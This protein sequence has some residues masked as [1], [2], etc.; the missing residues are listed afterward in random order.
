MD[1]SLT[2][3]EDVIDIGELYGVSHVGVFFLSILV[4]FC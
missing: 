3:L 2:G 1:K 4:W